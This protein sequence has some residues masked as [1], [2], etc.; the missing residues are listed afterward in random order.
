MA[1]I[2]NKSDGTVLATVADGTIDTTASSITLLGKGFNNYGEIAAEDWIHMMEHFATGDPGGP[3]NAIRGQLWFDTAE[4]KIKV[5]ISNIANSPDW[6]SIGAAAVQPTEPTSG[7]GVGSFWYNTTDDLLNISLDGSTFTPLRTTSVGPAA[8]G[9]AIEGDLFYDTDTKQLKVFNADLHDTASGGFDVVGPARFVGPNAPVTDVLDGDMWF[10]STNKQLHVYDQINAEFRLVG[11]NSPGGINGISTGVT[12]VVGNINNS[13]A[14]LEITI[15][16]EIIGIWSPEDFTPSPVITG[17]AS[18]LRGLNLSTELG[19]ASEPTL[20][21]GDATGA[22]YAD[23]AERYAVDGPI[24]A[25]EL[26]SIGGEAEV[27]KTTIEGDTNVF[28]VV[29]T[30]PGLRLNAAAG[31]DKTHPFIAMTGRVPC[32]VIGPVMKGERLVSSDVPGV[33]KAISDDAVAANFVAVFGRALETDASSG[34][35]TIEVIV[36]VK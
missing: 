26:V 32:K 29:S 6:I 5:N 28:G 35:K 2:V 24:E 25:G 7:F 9:G 11:P 16:D 21:A 22:F 4:G 13:V 18:I 33:A 12:N 34:T 14:I 30:N 20:L 31:D 1:Y 23:L 10:D 17:F 36:G 27:T 3:P 8:P 15:D 19:P